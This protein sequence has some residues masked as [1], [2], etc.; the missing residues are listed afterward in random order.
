MTRT[1]GEVLDAARKLT[2]PTEKA[3][4]LQQQMSPALAW[5]LQLAFS[6]VKWL[7]PEGTPPFKPEP[8]G[9]GLTAS[10]LM[11]EL[12]RLYIFLEGGIADLAQIRREL[13]FRD[14]LQVI[15]KTEVELLIAVKDKKFAKQFKCT[16]AFVKKT[17]PGLLETPFSIHFL[18]Q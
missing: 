18:K 13:L 12:R 7:V 14:L 5:L 11:R 8:G 10:H 3:A 16:E 4:Y 9:P 15:D 6:E 1:L 17:F 2:K